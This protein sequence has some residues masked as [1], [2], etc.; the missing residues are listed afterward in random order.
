MKS[1]PNC[2]VKWKEQRVEPW[3]GHAVYVGRRETHKLFEQYPTHS[4]SS[5]IILWNWMHE[6]TWKSC[7]GS[8][9]TLSHLLPMLLFVTPGQPMWVGVLRA[10]QWSSRGELVCDPPGDGLWPGAA[11]RP[12]FLDMEV[13]YRH[14]PLVPLHPTHSPTW[15][16]WVVLPEMLLSGL[17]FSRL[18]KP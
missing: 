16:P 8:Q 11:E 17:Y 10:I 12:R 6:N 4:R 5:I 3:V 14:L 7:R 15:F 9:F 2:I 18:V 13:R 1:N